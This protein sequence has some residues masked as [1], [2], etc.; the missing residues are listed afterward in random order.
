MHE[1]RGIVG[2]VEGLAGRLPCSVRPR[3]EYR[4]ILPVRDD[5]ESTLRDTGA[6]REDLYSVTGT[7]KDD[8][9]MADRAP[10]QEPGDPVPD[11]SPGPSPMLD[12]LISRQSIG[13]EDEGGSSSRESR[14][15]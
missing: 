14:R 9:G 11:A 5:D 8:V 3:V 6:L 1:E 10:L 4:G 15:K 12:T 2:N 13:V 7:Y